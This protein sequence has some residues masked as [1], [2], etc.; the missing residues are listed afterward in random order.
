MVALR[1]VGPNMFLQV[2]EGMEEGDSLAQ[3]LTHRQVLGDSEHE[4]DEEMPL[5]KA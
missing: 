3:V 1:L 5:M 4:T 2:L